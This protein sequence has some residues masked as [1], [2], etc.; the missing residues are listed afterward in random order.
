[1]TNVRKVAVLGTGIMG[2]PMARNLAKAGLEV[3]AWN[4][5]RE[6]AAPLEEDGV[7]VADSA[8]EAVAGA[9]AFVT[10]LADGDAVREVASEALGQSGDALWLQTSTVGLAATDELA[11]LA[12]PSGT[13]FVDCPVLGTKQPAEQGELTVLASGPDDVHDVAAPVF[14]AIGKQTVWLGGAGAGTRMKLVVNAWIQSLTAAVGQSVAL[15]E[16]LDLDPAVFLEILDGAPV[17]SPYAQLK[18]SQIIDGRLEDVSFS[19]VLARK[20]TRLVID[21][22][23]QTGLDPGLARA[24]WDRFN[25]AVELGRGEEDMAAVYHAFLAQ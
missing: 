5:T 15:A 3:R 14:D 17:G 1:M 23:E 16:A 20:D 4:R 8:A 11:E 13:A 2:G 21:A 18:G 6:K 7:T 25:A 24:V 22:L 19:T 9:E 12:R 10:M